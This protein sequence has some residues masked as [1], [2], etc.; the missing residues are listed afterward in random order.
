MI[1]VPIY[2]NGNK[3]GNGLSP[4]A[5]TRKVSALSQSSL[6]ERNTL[7]AQE[8]KPAI[9]YS[10]SSHDSWM[11][12]AGISSSDYKTVEQLIDSESSWNPNSI[13]KSSGACGLTQALPCSKLGNNWNDPVIALKWGD[14]YVKDRYGSWIAAWNFWQNESPKYNGSHWY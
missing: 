4:Y 11:Q 13:N 12:A 10:N 9:E 2:P 8:I 7:E 6:S 3:E 5:T 14:Q 1:F